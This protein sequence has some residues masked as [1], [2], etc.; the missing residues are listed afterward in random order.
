MKILVPMTLAA[1][2]AATA[3]PAAAQALKPFQ[4]AD[5]YDLQMVTNPVVSPDGGRVLFTRG[6]FDRGTD[7]RT[8]E[9]WLAHVDAAGKIIDKRLLIGRDVAPRQVSFSPDG[10]RIAYVCLLYT[11]RCV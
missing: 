11:S 7:R 4:P 3:L 5:I 9:L 8:S 6:T 10:S 2:L 1:L